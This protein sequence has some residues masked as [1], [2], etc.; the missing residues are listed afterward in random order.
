MWKNEKKK[1][2]EIIET[3]RSPPLT[4]LFVTD[5]S[6]F[7]WIRIPRSISKN[8]SYR[9]RLG[10]RICRVNVFGHGLVENYFYFFFGSFVI[11][12]NNQLFSVCAVTTFDLSVYF[13]T[14]IFLVRDPDVFV[15]YIRTDDIKINSIGRR[16]YVLR[17]EMSFRFF[18]TDNITP[19]TSWISSVIYL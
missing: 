17:A 11:F 15:I 4:F 8:Y 18:V 3:V 6:S 19:Y 10:A 2:N 9:R 5:K 12:A 16:L 13:N 7:D 1:I 14:V